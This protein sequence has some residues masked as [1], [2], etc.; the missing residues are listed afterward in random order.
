M[1]ILKM[2]KRFG[3]ISSSVR[4]ECIRQRDGVLTQRI[5]TNFSLLVL[6]RSAVGVNIDCGRHS[7]A[8]PHAL[9]PPK[10]LSRDVFL[11][12]MVFSHPCCC[13]CFLFF[14]FVLLVMYQQVH[15]CGVHLLE[16]HCAKA[17][18]AAAAFRTAHVQNHRSLE[19]LVRYS[20]FYCLRI[21]C[22]FDCNC[23]SF[24]VILLFCVCVWSCSSLPFLG[25]NVML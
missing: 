5:G 15:L 18:I 8:T 13:S 2:G 21:S 9:T 22:L 17:S 4:M 7:A 11:C 1:R 12:F 6:A 20:F 25:G 19:K 14:C 10:K 16:R 23:S 24:V 3:E